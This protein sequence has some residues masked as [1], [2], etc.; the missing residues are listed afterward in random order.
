MRYGLLNL[1]S[2]YLGVGHAAYEAQ[3]SV[4]TETDPRPD[5]SHIKNLYYPKFIIGLLP[6]FKPLAQNFLTLLVCVFFL[7]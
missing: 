2:M 1:L 7:F 3:N 6:I 5:S 4:L